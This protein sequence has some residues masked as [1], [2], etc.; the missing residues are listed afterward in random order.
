MEHG[1][2]DLDS[3]L[4]QGPASHYLPLTLRQVLSHL[5]TAPADTLHPWRRLGEGMEKRV[6]I[7]HRLVV[8]LTHHQS[9]VLL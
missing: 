1:G 7:G 4:M 2:G 6:V 8:V 9:P 5:L 3:Q